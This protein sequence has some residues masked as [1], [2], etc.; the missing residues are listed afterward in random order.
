LEVCKLKPE[1]PIDHLAEYLL[2]ASIKQQ[3]QTS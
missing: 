1:D 3:S 2:R